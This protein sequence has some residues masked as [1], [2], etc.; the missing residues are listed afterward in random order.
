M[1]ADLRG[2]AILERRDDAPAAG[3]VLRVR[4]GHQEDVDG[5]AHPVALHLDVALLHHV[6][7]PHLHLL[8]EVRKHDDAEDPAVRS[9]HEAEVDRELVGEPAPLGHPH[10][11][12]VT[13]QVADGDIRRRQLLDVALVAMHPRDLRVV[14][15]LRDRCAGGG[16]DR[17]EG[18]VVDLA[19]G[20][21]RQPFVEER[22]ERADHA[23]LRLT[24]L[25][26]EDQVVT[27][28]QRVHQRREHRVVVAEHA[29]ADALAGAQAPQEVC[30]QLLAD[31]AGAVATAAK[32]TEAAG[33]VDGLGGGG[34]GGGYRA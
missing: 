33:G 29:L 5:Q 30:A 9:R 24:A 22:D 1:G 2:V 34:G 19:A 13:D 6:E 12:Y 21:L 3:V 26:Q 8:G 10:R 16:G 23:R 27:T 15:L 18:V 17:R 28:E 31:A 25:S 32:L 11:V 7:Q 20:H 14:T 4:A